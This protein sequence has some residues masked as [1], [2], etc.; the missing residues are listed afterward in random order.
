[1][2]LKKTEYVL[3]PVWIINYEYKGEHY[4]FAMNGQTG[5]TVGV[6]PVSKAKAGIMVGSILGVLWGLLTA[7]GGVF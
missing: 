3:L 1:M 4:R 2:S 7:F 5:K 6:L